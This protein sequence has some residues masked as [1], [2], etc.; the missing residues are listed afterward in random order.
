MAKNKI[1]YGDETLIDLTSD[2]VSPSTLLSGETAHDRSGE[3]IVGT[4]TVPDE[5]NDLDDVNIS[6]PTGGQALIYDSQNDEWVN[7]TVSAT[8]GH[9]I[10]NDSGTSLTQRDT[11]Q[12][13]GTYSEDDSTNS[14][15]VVHVVRHVT[16]RAAYNALSNEEKKGVVVIDNESGGSNLFYRKPDDLQLSIV[17]GKLCIT[18]DDG[19]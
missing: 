18:Y 13:K 6:S 14:R 8:G 19:T 17:N 1:I 2:T 5:L 10:K 11:L 7:G 3:S 12:F 16:D 4:V 9:I 15:T